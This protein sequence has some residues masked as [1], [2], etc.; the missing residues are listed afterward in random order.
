MAAVGISLIVMAMEGIS[1]IVSSNDVVVGIRVKGCSTRSGSAL[2]V[3]RRS[4]VC[5]EQAEMMS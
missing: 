2:G 5:D 1:F 4:F 3:M